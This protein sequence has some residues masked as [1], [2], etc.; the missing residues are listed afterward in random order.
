MDE[1]LSW[2]EIKKRFPNEWVCLVDV[3]RPN[4]GH[5]VSGV[6]YAHDPQ[7]NVLLE[8]QKHLEFAGIH[9]TGKRRGRLI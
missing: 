9:W 2:E 3:D 1:R 6:V 7:H 8:K 5:V 4:M